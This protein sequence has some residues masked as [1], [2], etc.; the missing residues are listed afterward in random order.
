MSEHPETAGR[1]WRPSDHPPPPPPGS[2][3]VKFERWT[4]TLTTNARE[5]AVELWRDND[6]R[7][8]LPLTAGQAELLLGHPHTLATAIEGF[9]GIAGGGEA[10]T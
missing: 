8:T 1:E 5:S 2:V 7:L 6:H 9:P 10:V 4:W 3:P